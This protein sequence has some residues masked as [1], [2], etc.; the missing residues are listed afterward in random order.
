MRTLE[1]FSV[2][3]GAVYGRVRFDGEQLHAEGRARDMIEDMTPAEVLERYDGWSNGYVSDRR[4]GERPLTR[5]R[6]PVRL[7]PVAER[8]AALKEHI[9][10]T[11]FFD[12]KSR[13]L[14]D[15][16]ALPPDPS[17]DPEENEGP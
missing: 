3:S 15:P 8:D 11:H 4:L 2:D 5:D 14:Y 7:R 10:T 6:G 17:P 9:E 1:F 13:E 12:E 16:K